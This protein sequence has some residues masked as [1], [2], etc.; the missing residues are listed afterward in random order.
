MIV[1][2]GVV[3]GVVVVIA[4]VVVIVV[5]AV[6]TAVVGSVV[7]MVG[8]PNLGYNQLGIV[9]GVVVVSVVVDVS[10]SL[11]IFSFNPPSAWKTS[12]WPCVSISS[13]C[14]LAR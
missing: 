14:S 10:S 13:V 9:P 4:V 6:A 1:V 11:R 5:V 8:N 2:G 3:P 12:L 7:V